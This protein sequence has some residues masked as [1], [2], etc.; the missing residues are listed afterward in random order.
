M[1][2]G[3]SFSPNRSS[4]N[5]NW[6]FVAEDGRGAHGA[7]VEVKRVRI[8]NVHMIEVKS[9]QQQL[10]LR[11]FTQ[12]WPLESRRYLWWVK[13]VD[14]GILHFGSALARESTKEKLT[15]MADMELW[16]SR[17]YRHRRRRHR[18]SRSIVEK[19]GTMQKV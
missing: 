14:Q 1:R 16:S 9:G 4:N 7:C 19:K 6:T 3:L 15:L 5:L 17:R 12:I 10:N 8:L 2:D 13:E 18:R 11:S